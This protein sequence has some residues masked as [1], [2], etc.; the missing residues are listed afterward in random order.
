MS[1]LTELQAECP[2][3]WRLDIGQAATAFDLGTSV[4]LGTADGDVVSI[5]PKTGAVIER[6][7]R[8]RGEVMS[9]AVEPVTGR[10]ATAGADG[11]VIVSDPR[12]GQRV[13]HAFARTP[14]FVAWQPGGGGLAYA[15]GRTVRFQ[16]GDGTTS[17]FE[18][19]STA[20]GLAFSADGRKLAAA[21][22]GGV[23]ILA[24]LPAC[25]KEPTRL[26]MVGSLVSLTW[27][28]DG[29]VVACATQ[30]RAVAFWRV[31]SNIDHAS[32]MGGYPA[33]VKAL[34]WD[35]KSQ[36]LATGGGQRV[37]IWRFRGLGPEGTKPLE[38]EAH[39][40]D[41]SALAFHPERRLLASAGADG[42][43]CIWD[44][45]RDRPLTMGLVGSVAAPIAHLAWSNDG[46]LLVASD[47]HGF[48]AAFDCP[49]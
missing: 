29:K 6:S 1:R 11:T 24:T 9:L 41:V 7:R 25:G 46:V 17:D 15:F 36:L 40:D 19:E 43:V 30:D 22:F 8:H 48:V 28:P 35:P 27:S 38:L 13:V 47:A 37:T 49:P 26:P 3:R 5:E 34:A 18:L 14:E 21:A 33:K 45:R 39:Q 20:T 4:M 32:Q 23:S 16:A 31:L 44:L 2:A 12:G 10:L 42:A